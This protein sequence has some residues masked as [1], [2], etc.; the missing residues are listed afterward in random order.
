MWILDIKYIGLHV[1]KWQ[2]EN[3]INEFKQKIIVITIKSILC[4][5]GFVQS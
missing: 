4:L 1:L 3:M 2:G 5:S